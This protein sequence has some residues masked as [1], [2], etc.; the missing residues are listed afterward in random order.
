MS[1]EREKDDPVKVTLPHSTSSNIPKSPFEESLIVQNDTPIQ[2]DKMT[3]PHLAA[4]SASSVGHTSAATSPARSNATSATFGPGSR[5]TNHTARQDQRRTYSNRSPNVSSTAQATDRTVPGKMHLI[6]GPGGRIL[7]VADV[8][9]NLSSLN[10]L[11]AQTDAQAIIHSGDFGFYENESFERISDRT[12]RHLV[13]YSTLIPTALRTKLLTA[14]AP[15]AA[16]TAGNGTNANSAMPP[17]TTPCKEMRNQ[18]LAHPDSPILTEFPSLLS[19]KLRLN[20]PVYTVWG[21]CEDVRILEK[22]RTKEYEIEN[23]HVL[24]EA[25][26][27][28]L[29]VGG[30]RLRLFGLGGAVVLHKLFDNGE[31]AATIAGGQGTMWTTILQIGELIDT[32][33]KCYDP[34]ETRLLITHASPGREGL[35]MQLALALK[36]DLTISAG[37]HFRYGVSYNEFSVQSDPEQF[38][39]KLLQSKS[40]FGE[41]WDS[42]RAQVEEVV[43]DQQRILLNN[44]LAV[45]N[46]APTQT[47]GTGGPLQEEPAWKNTWN[48]NLPD[49]AFGHLVLDISEGKVSSEMKSEGFNFAYRRAEAA[50]VPTS[51]T[52][53]AISPAAVPSVPNSAAQAARQQQSPK[54]PT[55]PAKFRQQEGHSPSS[56]GPPSRGQFSSKNPR[57]RAA[58]S[59]SG[60]SAGAVSDQDGNAPHSRPTSSRGAK[61]VHGS[62]SG[63]EEAI[64]RGPKGAAN[65]DKSQPTGAASAATKEAKGSESTKGETVKEITTTAAAPANGTNAIDEHQSSVSRSGKG[66]GHRNK[67]SGQ[68]S[69]GWSS[70]SEKSASESEA[71]HVAKGNTGGDSKPNNETSKSVGAES[72]TERSAKDDGEPSSAPARAGGER[73]RGRGGSRGSR[74]GR[75]GRGGHSERRKSAASNGG[76]GG[77]QKSGPPAGSSANKAD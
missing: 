71:K 1:N 13:Q 77:E 68:S 36:A 45:T 22:I 5:S 74:G 73:G 10:K 35:L 67:K 24:D 14:D 4:P 46:R 25:S 66:R 2:T 62:R 61:H 58:N 51:S 64:T 29:E 44:G 48:W 7:C 39:R 59:Q 57:H 9:G 18:I 20:V 3:S 31:G 26:T 19:G 8:R 50:S 43:D 72:G 28:A 70:K 47:T 60:A 32:A 33:Q 16:R 53:N 52:T 76:G 30:V 41:V 34:S 6:E 12:L 23:L 17:P 15:G 42:V 37:L 56:T 55:G 54:I 27:V 69:A 11:A 21:A 38:R 65:G 49:A 75:G 40:A 63:G